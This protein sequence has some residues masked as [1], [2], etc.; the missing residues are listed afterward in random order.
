MA[1][2]EFRARDPGRIQLYARRRGNA[3]AAALQATIWWLEDEAADPG[4][5]D[6]FRNL[7]LSQ[8]GSQTNAQ[9]DNN[10]LYGVAAL[11]LW[12]NPDNTGNAQDQ[13]VLIPGG[14]KQVP[15]GG[16][17][18]MLLGVGLLGIFLGYRRVTR[19]RPLSA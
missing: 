13:L 3:S 4:A 16:T 6:I 18:A 9:V 8:F 10:G 12:T 7:V 11:N 1:L 5:G 15:D 2:R 17:T 19:K 14:T